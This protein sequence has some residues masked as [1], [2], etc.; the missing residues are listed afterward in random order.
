MVWCGGTGGVV[1]VGVGVGG[2]K[3]MGRAMRGNMCFYDRL[4]G[5]VVLKAH[6]NS[7]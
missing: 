2:L 5:M 4:W 1:Q 3:I 7:R 6:F